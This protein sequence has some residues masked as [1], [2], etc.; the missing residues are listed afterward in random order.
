MRGLAT[1]IMRGRM[2]AALATIG[3]MALSMVVPPLSYFSGAA[4]GLVALRLGW[5]E[6]AIV[7]GSAVMVVLSISAFAEQP[8]LGLTFAVVVWVPVWLLALVLRRTVSLPLTLAVAALIGVAA[9]IA[10][11]VVVT[12]PAQWWRE[13]VIEVFTSQILDQ[14]GLD[15]EQADLWRTSL[16]QMAPMMTGIVA[17]AFVFSAAFSL[18]I[19]R[20]WQALL[21]NP[22]G[23]R[24]EFQALRLGKW[25]AL[26]ASGM[27]LIGFAPLGAVSVAAKDGSLVIVMLYMLQGLALVHA[28]VSD[29]GAHVAW[30]I[31]L[32]VL[33]LFALPQVMA[34]LALLGFA[35]TWFN[36]RNHMPQRPKQS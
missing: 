17:A 5:R 30:L 35:D 21:Y 7:L 2:H 9:V 25:L 28:W 18:F 10:M 33:M 12:D 24:K 32:Y 31:A 11:H 27:I 13:N 23:F 15:K 29:Y 1:F 14:A 8:A 19:A 36:V 34:L 4:L 6:S 22:G 3:L 16:D 26:I 20:W